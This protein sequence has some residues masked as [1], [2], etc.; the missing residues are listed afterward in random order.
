[1]SQHDTPATPGA[2]EERPETSRKPGPCP[3]RERKLRLEHML[4]TAR[5]EL[6]AAQA[7]QLE[8]RG[9]QSLDSGEAAAIAATLQGFDFEVC[10]AIRTVNRARRL[11]Q[12]LAGLEVKR[13]PGA[14]AA[15]N[16]RLERE[17]EFAAKVRSYG[18]DANAYIAQ[19]PG[20][21]QIEGALELD[22]PLTARL[23][24]GEPEPSVSERMQAQLGVLE[25]IRDGIDDLREGMHV[26]RAGR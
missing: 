11:V 8:L 9:L 12:N 7:L 13:R 19:L 6:E 2:H 24:I 20:A 22:P 14:A 10:D 23:I 26:L 25:Q 3:Y 16:E 4:E 17:V 15:E 1:M 18:L 5:E 21:K